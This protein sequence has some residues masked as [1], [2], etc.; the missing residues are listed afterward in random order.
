MR[1]YFLDKFHKGQKSVPLGPLA[2]PKFRITF[3]KGLEVQ[4]ISVQIS[5]PGG[6]SHMTLVPE[7]TH[8]S[9]RDLN[10]LRLSKCWCLPELGGGAA[11]FLQIAFA[12]P[13]NR[14]L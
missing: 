2:R 7:L 4:K 12:I 8:L 1:P 9:H 11:V 14:R 10:R 3:G 6:Q 13:S 5:L